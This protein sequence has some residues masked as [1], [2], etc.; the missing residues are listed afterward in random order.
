MKGL[1]RGFLCVGLIAFLVGPAFGETSS[2]DLEVQLE[3]LMNQ[4]KDM[5]AA[6]KAQKAEIEALQ[7]KL[8]E[9]QAKEAAPSAAAPAAVAKEEKVTSKYNLKIY[10]KIKFDGIYDTNNM[11]RDEFITFIPKNADGKDKATFNVRDTRLGIAITGPSLNGW[12]ATGR[13]ETDFYG[14]DP[15]SNGQ[16]RIRLSYID[17]AKGGTSIR[18]GQ[19]WTQIAYLNPNTIDFAIM[20][21]NGNLW[22]R[23]PQV[24]V[25]QNFGGGLEGL[26]TAYRFLSKDDGAN[27]QIHMPWVGAKLSYTT[28][29]FE[30]TEKAYFAVGASVRNGDA[31][32]NDVTPYL[33]ALEAKIPLPFVELSGEAYMGQGLGLEYFHHLG[34]DF[35]A[36][37]NAI[38]TRGAWIQASA[39][40]VKDVMV[41][42]GY[43]LDDPKNDNVGVDFYRKS[44]Y[45]FGNLQI[46]LFKDIIAG[47][48][49]AYVET[50]W[51]ATTG[52]EYGTRFQTSL[53]YNW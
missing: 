7:N 40:P 52:P 4:V 19:D 44:E 15:N 43:G 41:N 23:V 13:F 38:L 50:D 21:F 26:V 36:R 28:A 8:K 42:V 6:M 17:F 47:I 27:V 20:G 53:I 9:L 45:T 30:K 49:A 3:K 25:R 35:N 18:V 34:G 32:G 31:K 46:Q 2:K 51:A 33:T 5:D 12:Q 11:G 22:N 1:L 39:K 10:G 24:T 48:E 29:L 16:L 14:S 37:G